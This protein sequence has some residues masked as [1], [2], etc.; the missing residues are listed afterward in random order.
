MTAKDIERVLRRLGDIYIPEFTYN[1][2]RIDAILV[3][4]RYRKVRGFEIKVDK[5]DFLKDK[6]WQ[7]YSKF[8][9]SLSVACPEGLIEPEEVSDPFGLLW[10]K[11]SGEVTWKKR[12]KNIQHRESLAWTWT[13]LSVIEK[14]LARLVI[15]NDSFKLADRTRRNEEALR[16]H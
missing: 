12:E 2:L 9:S 8:C 1:D 3:D 7:L 15:E 14:E 10:I 4:I 13:Y 11:N 6:K 5:G 16:G